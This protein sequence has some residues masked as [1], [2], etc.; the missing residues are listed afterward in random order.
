M[1]CGYE[2][3]VLSGQPFCRR[4]KPAA[5]EKGN[6]TS[7]KDSAQISQIPVNSLWFANIKKTQ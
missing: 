3:N 2:N 1:T 4:F 5:I 7:K 6:S